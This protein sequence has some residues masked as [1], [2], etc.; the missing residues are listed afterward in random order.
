M[1]PEDDLFAETTT[2]ETPAGNGADKTAEGAEGDKPLTTKDL[3]EFAEQFVTPNTA[4]MNRISETL[5]S[6]TETLTQMQGAMQRLG[7]GSEQSEGEFDA[8]S[9]ITDPKPMV[10][11]ITASAIAKAL[12]DQVAPVMGQMIEQNH[13]SVVAEQKADVDRVFG[14]GTWDKEFAP[15]LDPIFE[16]ARKDN[17]SSLGSKVAISKAVDSIKGMKFDNL[18]E[19][20][21]TVDQTREETKEAR[22]AKMIEVVTSNLPGGIVRKT[23]AS[24]LPEEAK[25]YLEAEFKA[26]GQKPDEGSF[27]ASLKSGS[28][29]T[30]WR[31]AQP[32]ESK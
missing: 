28:T 23:G 16:N 2:V 30:E 18:V 29:L 26:T 27:L 21:K 20:R 19:A 22:E 12:K 7:L 13:N 17:P 24:T 32:K 31:A 3:A 5:R 4:Q 1:P 15:E 6:T 25:Q 8:A 14:A 11:S 10:E 9:F